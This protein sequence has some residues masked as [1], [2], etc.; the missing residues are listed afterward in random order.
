M[1]HPKFT[2][3]AAL[4]ICCAGAVSASAADSADAPAA[5]ADPAAQPNLDAP[6]VAADTLALAQRVADW[7]WL[8]LPS[9]KDRDP[10]GWEIAPFYLG[11]LALDRIAP[12]RRY[13]ELMIRQ[14][15]GNHW[16]PGD[17]LYHAD[18]HCVIQAYLELYHE[19]HEPRMLEPSRQR[20]DEILAHPSAA[21]FD[22]GQPNATDHWT[23]CDALFM[24]PMSWLLMWHETGDRRYLDFMNREWWRTTDLLYN[25]AVGL[26]FRDASFLHRREPNGKTVHWSRGNGWVFA[27]LVRVLA[28]FPRDHP[29]YP[30]YV[31]L[32]HE[33]AAAILAAQQPDG[34]WRGGL[35][36]P[37]AHPARETSG[38]AFFA[39][40][41][42][43]G[44]NHG[45]LDRARAEP[46]IRRAWNAL[47][48]CVTPDGKLE[49]VQPIG[50]AP[51]NFDPHH[52]DVFAVG[53]F[54][55]AAAE[56]HDFAAP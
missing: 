5:S 17:R 18:D 47:A 36:D 28:L 13:R 50:S 3:C 34:L 49:H 55:L 54:L 31:A 30:R 48:A 1:P 46:A 11:T 32:Y 26:Y 22:W 42:A 37:A 52:T 19:L 40:G 44:V 39:F 51:G 14:A 9:P 15:D 16:Q 25:R 41:L 20:L 6:L 7:Q 2:L 8:H 35:L 53:A 38:S 29:D 56:V 21:S 10:R 43:A 4:F 33:M 23:W 24:G 27:A 45:L 12:D